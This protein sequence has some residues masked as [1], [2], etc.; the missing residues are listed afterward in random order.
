MTDQPEN[1]EWIE[2]PCEWRCHA[3]DKGG[4]VVVMAR[5]TELPLDAAYRHQEETKQ[6]CIAGCAYHVEFVPPKGAA[7]RND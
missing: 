5:P 6:R 3:C 7:A 2:T 4:Y 1:T